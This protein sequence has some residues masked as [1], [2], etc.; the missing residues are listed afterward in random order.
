MIRKLQYSVLPSASVDLAEADPIASSLFLRSIGRVPPGYGMLT[1]RERGM[2]E[3]ILQY[4]AEG[5]GWFDAGEGRQAIE[6]GS[7]ILIPPKAMHAYGADEREPWFNYWIHLRGERARRY[8]EALGL[9]RKN[10]LVE[11]RPD[12]EMVDC[13]DTILGIYKEG[14]GLEHL[15]DASSWLNRLLT[16]IVLC[17]RGRE[18]RSRDGV[19]DSIRFMKANID[20]KL[21]LG[22]LA[23]SASLSKARYHELFR[24]RIGQAPMSYFAQ[25]KLAQAGDVLATRDDT[26][27]AIAQRFGYAN[28]FYFSRV[29]K[30]TMGMPPSVYRERYRVR[31][32]G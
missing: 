23:A 25:L 30:K 8:F 31:R 5:R 28:A 16:R 9:D 29:F 6:A 17:Q 1:R 15:L 11:I 27:E 20:R 18:S 14:Y 26:I 10:W 2:D 13:F 7:C 24:E 12:A 32:E 3:Y 4:C 19:A 22:E 21:S